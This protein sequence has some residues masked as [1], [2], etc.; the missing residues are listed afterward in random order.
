MKGKEEGF[1]I[2]VPDKDLQLYKLYL[3]TA[4]RTLMRCIVKSTI[5][6]CLLLA[7]NSDINFTCWF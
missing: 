6:P 4:D 1:F 5:T 7:T 3:R 2:I